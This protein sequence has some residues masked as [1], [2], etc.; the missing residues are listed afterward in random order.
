VIERAWAMV[1]E[2]GRRIWRVLDG[3]PGEHRLGRRVRAIW[4]RLRWLPRTI[5][6]L[7][8][9]RLF[10]LWLH[11]RRLIVIGAVAL[12]VIIGLLVGVLLEANTGG[13][14][15]IV[16]N[17]RNG[18]A[19]LKPGEHALIAIQ[20]ELLDTLI[21]SSLTQGGL[22]VE[23]TNVHTTF[24]QKGIKVSGDAHEKFVPIAISWDVTVVPVA[25]PDGTIGVRV[26]NVHAV[27][28]ALPRFFDNLI[29]NA[30]NQQLNKEVGALP[31]YRAT[32]VE[33]GNQELLVYF[34]YT[35]P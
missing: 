2:A 12:A 15:K 26:V 20:A 19:M 5:Y 22:P 34:T 23:F 30:I 9:I 32:D 25:E 10:L 13:E 1:R 6:R 24:T 3:A 11:P 21:R 33:F 29:E 28:G 31:G 18:P 17:A 4:R 27:G 16:V 35:P 7:T 14:T 8:R